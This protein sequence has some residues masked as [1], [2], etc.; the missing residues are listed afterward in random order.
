MLIAVKLAQRLIVVHQRLVLTCDSGSMALD[1][2]RASFR[3]CEVDCLASGPPMSA[4]L[5]V[6]RWLSCWL[7]LDPDATSEGAEPAGKVR[8]YVLRLWLDNRSQ[9]A[10]DS[11][12]ILEA[13]GA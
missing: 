8:S 2:A 1:S 7:L 9:E 4:G 10:A 11:Q 3:V 12:D 5:R 6:F 13:A